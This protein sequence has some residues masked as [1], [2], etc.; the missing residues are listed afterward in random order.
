MRT[1]EFLWAHIAITTLVN[2]TGV[3]ERGLSAQVE[4]KSLISRKSASRDRRRWSDLW[5]TDLRA[6]ILPFVRAFMS[7]S[8]WKHPF[9]LV[10]SVGEDAILTTSCPFSKPTI[11]HLKNIHYPFLRRSLRSKPKAVTASYPIDHQ[12]LEKWSGTPLPYHTSRITVS[13]SAS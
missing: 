3:C 13:Q 11:F 9:K 7:I 4:R 10:E 2:I 1:L 12:S 6:A 8:H 5:W